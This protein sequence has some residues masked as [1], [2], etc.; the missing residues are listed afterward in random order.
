MVKGGKNMRIANLIAWIILL[1]GG[2]NWLLIGAFSWNLVEAITGNITW[3]AR[4]IYCLVGVSAIWLFVTP[5]LN[6]GKISMWN[7]G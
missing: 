3:L 6:G 2:L 4:T 5:I 7:V 1:I